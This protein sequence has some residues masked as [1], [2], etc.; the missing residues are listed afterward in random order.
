MQPLVSVIVCVYNAKD[1]IARC[2]DSILC[3]SINDFELIVIDDGSTDGTELLLDNYTEADN[4]MIVIHQTNQGVAVARQNGIDKAI[5]KYTLFVDADDWIEPDMLEVLTGYASRTGSEM[6]F[7]DYSEENEAGVF[8]RKQDP[9]A[10][11]STEVLRQMLIQLNG[12]LWNKLI[13]RNLYTISRARFVKGLNFCEDEYIVIRLLSYGCKVGYVGRAFYHYD[14]NANTA[15][16]TNQWNIRTAE[17]YELFVK[18]CAPYLNTAPLKR[19]LDERIAGIIKRMTHAPSGQYSANRV[20]YR[21]H[22]ASLWRSKMSLSRKIYC[23]L[24]FNGFR[25]IIKFSKVHQDLSKI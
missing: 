24:F 25:G 20:F 16:Y 8:Y 21:R 13:L 19:N 6:V 11:E 12:F 23:C 4:R 7:C 18:N 14:K 9:M 15:S 22:K 2:L 1:T 3:Q 10:T 17:E 5:G